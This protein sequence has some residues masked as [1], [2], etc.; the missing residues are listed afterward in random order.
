M[1]AARWGE[2]GNGPAV[3]TRNGT[4]NGAALVPSESPGDF[5]KRHLEYELSGQFGRSWDELH[6]AHQK[7]VSRDRY[8]ACRSELFARDA[9]PAR[10]ESFDV[11]EVEDEPIDLPEIPEQTWKA[12]RVKFTVRG[13]AETQL[14]VDTVHAIQVRNRW[15]WV[16]PASAYRAYEEGS[17]PGRQ[18]A[19]HAAL[20]GAELARMQGNKDLR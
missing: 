4:Q 1:F 18:T 12:V 13:G 3:P 17:A 6:P 7:V 20:R 16:L 11:L 8:G 2:N 15:T 5:L 19:G 14:A 10:L 9:V